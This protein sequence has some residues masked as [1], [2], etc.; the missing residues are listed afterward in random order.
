M[1]PQTYHIEAVAQL[2]RRKKSWKVTPPHGFIRKTYWQFFFK[3]VSWLFLISRLT[4]L[5]ALEQRVGFPLR[6]HRIMTQ[7]GWLNLTGSCPDEVRIK[8]SFG[9]TELMCPLHQPYLCVESSR[10]FKGIEEAKSDALKT[11]D[12]YTRSVYT[13]DIC[14]FGGNVKHLIIFWGCFFL[15]NHEVVRIWKSLYATI[16]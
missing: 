5:S 4:S 11:T 12:W 3:W 15:F 2:R 9:P 16:R 6:E 10:T 7:R 1:F 8:R 14:A 13:T